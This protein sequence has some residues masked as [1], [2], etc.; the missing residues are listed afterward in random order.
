[1]SKSKENMKI[2]AVEDSEVDLEILESILTQLGF[3]DI[4]KARNGMEAVHLA[5]E[6]HPDLIISDIMMPGMDG[7][8]MRKHLKNNHSTMQIPV[9]FAS[10]IIE[11]N[12]EKEF[13][14][15]LVGEEWLVA[16]PY[17]VEE[18]SKAIDAILSTK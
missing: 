5:K 10:S 12:E 6:Q 1:M 3:Q 15:R 8:E 2:L 17:S 18:I 7:G 11:K 9:I 16:K 13:G 4:I 14:G